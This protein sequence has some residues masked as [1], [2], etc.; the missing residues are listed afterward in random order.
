VSNLG[1]YQEFSTA[2]KVAGGV[3][4]YLRQIKHGAVLRAAPFLIGIG[5][6]GGWAAR[7][8]NEKA[9]AAEARLRE[10]GQH[11]D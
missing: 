11:D 7:K 4:P 2:A 6:V 1:R 10:M 5:A 3:D 8:I 9:R